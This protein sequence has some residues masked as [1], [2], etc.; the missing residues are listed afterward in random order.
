MSMKLAILVVLL[1]RDMHP[2]EMMLVMKDRAMDRLT[3]LQMGSLYYAVDQ[4][5]KNGEIEQVEVIR[6][7]DRPEKTVY[8][9]TDAGRAEFEQL[10]LQQ[11]RKNDTVYHPMYI[12]L[13]FSRHADPLKIAKLLEE[14][15]R[16]VEHEVHYMYQ[17][18]EEHIPSVSR[19]ALHLMYGRYEHS[20]AELKW[21]RRLH[22]DTLA[23]RLGTV[24]EP[25]DVRE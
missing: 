17:I 16:D 5:A 8:R 24:G 1:E 20:L 9:I 6:S 19:A 25:L 14:R 21:L 7:S 3:K 12:A 10:L 23:N 22:A 2:Y 18:Y 15:I 11:F 13:A 4:L